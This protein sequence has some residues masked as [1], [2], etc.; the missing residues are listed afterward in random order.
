MLPKDLTVAAGISKPGCAN[1]R[2][3]AANTGPVNE[4]K[5]DCNLLVILWAPQHR[6]YGKSNIQD[7][8]NR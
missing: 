4:G 5:A 2:A 6:D 8:Y 3:E 7:T 1:D